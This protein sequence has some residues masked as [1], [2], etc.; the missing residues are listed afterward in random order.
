MLAT[1]S[2]WRSRV[3]IPSGTLGYGT[4]RK[5]AKRPISRIGDLRVRLPPVP[6]FGL[7]SSR[8]PV[9][10]L[11]RKSEVDDK[12]FNSFT[13]QFDLARSSIGSGRRPLKPQRRVRFPHGLFCE[14]T[15]QVVKLADTRRSERRA[16]RHGSSTLPLVT[17][18]PRR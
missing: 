2:Q 5:S 4:V 3:Q 1:L 16:E 7:C 11:S 8:R 14:P 15:G 12:R 6:L 10:P 13:T 17:L 9:K 18:F